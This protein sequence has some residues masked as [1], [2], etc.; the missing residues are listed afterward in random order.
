MISFNIY[1]VCSLIEHRHHDLLSWESKA[2][3]FRAIFE[4][5]RCML[6]TVNLT[7]SDNMKDES[8]EKEVEIGI[9]RIRKGLKN[10]IL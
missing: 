1:D 6:S 4:T 3:L 10:L 9:I 5:S 2:A 7:C 8:I